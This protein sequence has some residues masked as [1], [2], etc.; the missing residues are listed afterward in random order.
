MRARRYPTADHTYS[1]D[2]EE[3]ERFRVRLT[4]HHTGA[5]D[6]MS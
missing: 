5:Y 2:P 1:I 6:F 4:E 3:L